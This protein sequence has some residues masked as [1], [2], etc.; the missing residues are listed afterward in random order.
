MTL[1]CKPGDMAVLERPCSKNNGLIVRIIEKHE[2]ASSLYNEHTWLV[3][4]A[5]PA[6]VMSGPSK[7]QLKHEA[8]LFDRWLRPIRPRPLPEDQ[9]TDE[10][11][12]A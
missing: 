11:M 9:T 10:E 12:A 7:G 6:L 4:S 1:R 2:E 3:K 8:A 5:W